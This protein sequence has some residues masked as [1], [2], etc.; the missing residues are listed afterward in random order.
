MNKYSSLGTDDS[1]LSLMER[2]VLSLLEASKQFNIGYVDE[3]N[4]KKHNEKTHSNVRG[5][6]L[7][8]NR[9]VVSIWVCR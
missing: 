9:K 3:A 2:K 6:I 1:H 4:K 7:A 8:L 5:S